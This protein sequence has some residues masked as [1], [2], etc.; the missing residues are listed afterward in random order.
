MQLDQVEV[1]R[2]ENSLV[3]QE[4]E[5]QAK[6]ELGLVNVMGLTFRQL[7]GEEGGGVDVVGK[8]IWLL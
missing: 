3:R 1:A 7:A 2:E 4:E 5:L 8:Q 6:L